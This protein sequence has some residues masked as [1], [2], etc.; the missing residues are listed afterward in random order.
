[1]QTQTVEST[2]VKEKEIV[3]IR[4]SK[5]TRER[6]LAVVDRLNEKELGRKVIP[7]D[8]VAVAMTLVKAEHL[9][10]IQN[11]TLS[12]F[13][14]L[15]RDYAAYATTHEGVSMDEYLGKVLTGAIPRT[16]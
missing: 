10:Q 15:K 2:S 1:M 6:V 14:R 12:N 8:V 13:D 16:P 11:A 9:E 5:E 4:V 3:S 7:D